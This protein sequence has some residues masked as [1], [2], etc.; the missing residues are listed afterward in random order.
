VTNTEPENLTS[1]TPYNKSERNSMV[2]ASQK[3]GNNTMQI[4]ARIR[5]A[6]KG[7]NSIDTKSI[8]DAKIRN[9]IILYYTLRKKTQ[10][11]KIKIYAS[12]RNVE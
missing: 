5:Y 7:K 6:Q 9:A 12:K 4:N 2:G 11:H 1:L 3:K 8:I 10:R